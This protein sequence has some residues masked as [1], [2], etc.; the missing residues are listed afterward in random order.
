MWRSYVIDSRT[1]PAVKTGKVNYN[2][3]RE[4]NENWKSEA[5]RDA[6]HKYEYSYKE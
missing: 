6:V 4:V 2:P 5:E 1:E 3:R